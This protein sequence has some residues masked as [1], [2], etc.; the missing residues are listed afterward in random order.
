[1]YRTDRSAQTIQARIRR[2][3]FEVKHKD[4]CL[5]LELSTII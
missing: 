3:I 5:L 2:T 4:T 1:M